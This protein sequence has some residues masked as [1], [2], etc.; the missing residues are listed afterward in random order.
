MWR[1]Q[2]IRTAKIALFKILSKFIYCELYKKTAFSGGQSARVDI[3]M[4]EAS[5]RDNLQKRQSQDFHVEQ[6][7]M[8]AEIV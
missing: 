8:V 4:L 1:I 6:D 3:S 2:V 5:S 7:R